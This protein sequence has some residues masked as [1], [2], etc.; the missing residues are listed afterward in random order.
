MLPFAP[1]LLETVPPVQVA[2]DVQ[3]PPLP[4]IVKPAFEPVVSRIMPLF[5]PPF[6][7]ML[8][9]VKPLAP[10]V[11]FAT[12]KAVPEVVVSVLTIEELFCVALIV[13]PPVAVNAAFAPVVSD[14]PPVKFTVAP[15]FEVSEMPFEVLLTAPPKAAVPPV[16][17]EM[18]TGRASEVPIVPL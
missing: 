2:E 14:K 16:L 10:I 18:L 9:N 17:P 13:P 11:V 1:V 3:V 4:V 15:V 12:F 5:V 7:A 6:D 8:R